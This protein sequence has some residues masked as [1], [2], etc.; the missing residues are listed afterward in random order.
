MPELAGLDVIHSG[1]GYQPM[2]VSHHEAGWWAGSAGAPEPVYP[3]LQWEGRT[4]NRDTLRDYYLPWREVEARGV[5]IHIGEFGCYNRTANDTAMRWLVDLFGVFREFGWGYAMWN[6][7]GPF[8]IVEHGRP[9]AKVELLHGYKV[10]RAL[11]D[12]MVESKIPS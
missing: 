11:F 9:G 4:W 8:G 5:K 3:G 7:Q 6:F 1:R 10:D 12:L 2:P